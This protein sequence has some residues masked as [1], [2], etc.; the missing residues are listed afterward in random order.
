MLSPSEKIIYHVTS[1]SN[2]PN[3]THLIQD[4]RYLI[5]F[6]FWCPPQTPCKIS[7]FFDKDPLDIYFGIMNELILFQT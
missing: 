2:D 4:C 6:S 1:P 7:N 5:G 3:S